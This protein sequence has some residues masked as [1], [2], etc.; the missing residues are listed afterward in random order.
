MK[1][2]VASESLRVEL[3]ATHFLLSALEDCYC[4]FQIIKH[5]IWVCIHL[6]VI[7]WGVFCV[8]CSKRTVFEERK[9]KTLI[10]FHSRENV[11]I[12][13]LNNYKC[14]I[15]NKLNL[16]NILTTNWIENIC[17]INHSC[18]VSAFYWSQKTAACFFNLNFS[19]CALSILQLGLS[20]PVWCRCSKA[21]SLF[22]ILLGNSLTRM[23]TT[24]DAI[25]RHVRLT[26]DKLPT[27][28]T[29][30]HLKLT[31]DFPWSSLVVSHV[32]C[33]G[34]GGGR[35]RR[36]GGGEGWGA[37]VCCSF[38]SLIALSSDIA[39]LSQAAGLR[40][41]LVNNTQRWT[42]ACEARAK[43]SLIWLSLCCE[44]ITPHLPRQPVTFIFTTLFYF[45]HKSQISIEENAL[46]L[47]GYTIITF[48]VAAT[49]QPLLHLKVQ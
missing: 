23:P 22:S 18:T 9:Y 3:V 12:E 1:P 41:N 8:A 39:I 19:L 29:K 6:C 16:L 4:C 10:V 46:F 42:E 48:A 20:R 14:S 26:L 30:N 38:L 43:L 49:H 33:R 47:F 21:C 31:N 2:L 34:G 37:C 45:C 40:A 7:V 28:N 13:G 35:R 15:H 25:N 24:W 5:L 11:R 36:G 17:R 27:N 44:F 32:F